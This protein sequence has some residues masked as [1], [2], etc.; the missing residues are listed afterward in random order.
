MSPKISPNMSS[1]VTRPCSAP[2]SSTTRAKWLLSLAEGLEL[3][4]QGGG[5]GHEPGRRRQ[6]GDV[7]GVQIALLLHQRL[8]QMLGVTGRR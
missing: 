7:D 5:V 2:Y 6:G 8:G 3:L 1:S 4:F